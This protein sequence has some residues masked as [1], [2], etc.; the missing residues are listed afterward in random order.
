VERRETLTEEEQ[1]EESGA[2]GVPKKGGGIARQVGR[3]SGRGGVFTRVRQ[4]F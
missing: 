4:K 3:G 2:G 1:K